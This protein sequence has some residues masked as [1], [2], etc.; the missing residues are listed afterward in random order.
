MTNP[1]PRQRYLIA[2]WA[3]AAAAELDKAL[4]VAQHTEDIRL[5]ARVRTI[6]DQALGLYNDFHEQDEAI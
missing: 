3:D 2:I 5:I 6:R 1:T 4:D